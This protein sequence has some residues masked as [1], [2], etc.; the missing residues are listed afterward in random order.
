MGLRL[1][2]LLF[3]GLL[4]SACQQ[5]VKPDSVTVP[6]STH[7]GVHTYMLDNGMKVLVKEDHRSPVVVSQVW[8]KVGGSY[9]YD[10][11]TGISHAIEHMM[12]KG[13]DKHGPG[14]FSEIIAANGGR[15]NAF[16]SK[17]YT[18]YFQRI[19]SDRLP[20]CLELE[21]DRMRHLRLDE[22]EFKKE[23]EVIKEERRMRT[24]DN[25]TA[26][27]Y[28]Q[29]NAMAF[30]NSSYRQPVIGW[31]DDL[32]NM[33]IS[34]LR[35]WYHTWY[36]PNNAT[37]VVTGDVTGEQ[38]YQL[39]KKYFGPLKPSVIPDPK[40]RTEEK[41]LGERRIIIKAPAKLPYLVMGY[42]V[43]VL[44][45]AKQDW[46]PYALEVLA[47]VLDGGD[48]SRLS[49]ALIRG[50]I[51]VSASAGYELDSRQESLFMLDGSP[52][53]K[54]SVKQLEKALLK[55]VAKIKQTPPSTGELERVKA[56]VMASKV[57]EQDS[58]FYEAMQL[59]ILESVG[60]G[61]EKKQEYLKRIEAVTPEQVQAVARKYLILGHLTLARLVPLPLDGKTP[62]PMMGGDIRHVR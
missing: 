8:Y 62:R 28:E 11:I 23:I 15:E 27:A 18:A 39:A 40:P 50:E 5:A 9:E 34:D 38:V 19:A 16:T 48:S 30:T 45:T 42:K 12:F 25:P 4:L 55:Q 22:K 53:S 6:P 3:S 26:L 24:D 31:M 20:I 37:L 13:T 60:L 58:M 36:A 32:N 49:R 29:F 2:S 35:S 46:E 44:K 59:G 43:P 54:V 52:A 33:K 57:Y 14:E 51:A 21:A 61:W 41:Q 56:Q 1:L 7:D 47:G 10:G 17:D